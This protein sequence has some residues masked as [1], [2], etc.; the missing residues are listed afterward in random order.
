MRKG[1]EQQKAEQTQ[2]PMGCRQQKAERNKK[3]PVMSQLK[4]V[5]KVKDLDKEVTQ[6]HLYN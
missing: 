6:L 5:L 3:E 2:M 4:D 1:C